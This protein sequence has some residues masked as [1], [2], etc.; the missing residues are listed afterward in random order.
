[1]KKVFYLVSWDE[2]RGSESEVSQCNNNIKYA[3][4]INIITRF[5]T[6]ECTSP[7]VQVFH[8]CVYALVGLHFLEDMHIQ[9]VNIL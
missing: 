6:R 7:T 9:N 2:E 3:H 4:T 5:F 1:M 8:V